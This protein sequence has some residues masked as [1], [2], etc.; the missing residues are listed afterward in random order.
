MT[1]FVGP[2]QAPFRSCLGAGP[3]GFGILG[4]SR[5]LRLRELRYCAEKTEE[6]QQRNDWFGD[7][8]SHFSSLLDLTHPSTPQENLPAVM[9][10]YSLSS[11]RPSL[12]AR[13]FSAT[14]RRHPDRIWPCPPS[15]PS[16]VSCNV[17]PS[18]STILLRRPTGLPDLAG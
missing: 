2:T 12:L 9:L 11:Q 15:P 10:R 3:G 4:I 5:L 1:T 14:S 16:C 8:I 6:G 7:R 18:A 17:V 13:A